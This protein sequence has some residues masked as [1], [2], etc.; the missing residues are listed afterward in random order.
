MVGWLWLAPFILAFTPT[1]VWLYERGTQSA[2]SEVHTL[3][4]PL[5][6]AYLIREQL[7]LDPDPTPS[8]SPLGFLFLVPALLLVA[9]DAAMHTQMLGA[10]ALVIALPG[11]S[12]LL[13]GTR[14]TRELAFPLALAVFIVPIPTGMLTPLYS[15]LR[16]IAAIGTSW[17][18]PLLGTP[19]AR[20]GT[21]LAVPGLTVEVAD[22]CSGWSSLQA[23]VITALVLAHFSSSRKRRLVLLLSAIP[24]AIVCN[25]LRVTALVLLAQR[26]GADLLDTTLHPAS[27]VILFGVVIAVL[28]AIAGPD[29]MRSAPASGHRTAIST[30]FAPALALLC[31]LALV[32]VA[33]HAS[34]SLRGDD[35]ANP[36]ALVPAQASVDP[37]RAL[38]MEQQYK[39]SQWREGVL[40][41]TADTP[42]LRFAVIR[43]YEPRLLYYRGSRRLWQD[44]APGGDTIEWL[45]SDDGR[46]P[47]VRSKLSAERPEQPRAVIASLLV[48]EGEPV[49]QGWRAQLRAAPRQMFTG[50]RPMTLY[51]VR[52]DA[53]DGDREAMEKRAHAFLLDSWRNYRALCRR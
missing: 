31:A 47:I 1:A 28:F 3:F 22:N 45:E 8:S 46:L 19:I 51:T 13:L 26:Y 50:S 52:G 23:A 5:V 16:P 17:L 20:V 2:F 53:T 44:V 34:A 42:A 18:V 39:A 43:S 41:P 25:I 4:M 6:L 30:R 35:C 49:E 32:P 14:R 24:V 48:Y 21:A 40:P 33:M 10:I 27:G 15:V 37:A 29:A 9:L 12:L 11:L 38:L 7:K 36:A